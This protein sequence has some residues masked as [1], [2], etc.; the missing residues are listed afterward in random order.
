MLT[1][2]QVS[3]C[4]VSRKPIDSRILKSLEGFG[5]LILADGRLGP[6][7]RYDAVDLA[8]LDIIYTQ[9]DDCIVNIDA[10]LAQWDGKFVSNM[11]PDRVQ[12]CWESNTLTGWGSLYRK[13]LVKPAL[14]RYTR[15]YGYDS[16]Y[17]READRIFSGQNPH[18][19]VCVGVEDLPNATSSDR[20]GQQPDHWKRR[21]EVRKRLEGLGASTI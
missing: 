12:P 9:D 7:A 16:L 14:D 13:S 8:T 10:L 2:S 21:E 3:A 6:C 4:L 17:M 19:L 18:K 20:L 5:E 11:K 15:R 1:R